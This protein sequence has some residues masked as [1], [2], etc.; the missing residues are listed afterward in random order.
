M[1]TIVIDKS[2]ERKK[3][4]RA[5]GI[6]LLSCSII[7]ILF[8]IIKWNKPVI[9]KPLVEEGIEVNL[10]DGNTGTGDIEPQVPGEPTSPTDNASIPSTQ[11]ET[12]S[13]QAD[14]NGDVPTAIPKTNTPVIKPDV[15][16]IIPKAVVQPKP[17]QPKAQMTKPKNQSGTRSD[18]Y[19][20]GSQGINGGHGNQGSPDGNPNASNY[21]DRSGTGSGISIKNGLNG[22]RITY[23]KM[24]GNFNENAKVAIDV[25]V[26]AA[27]KL[28]S[29]AIS[30]K[31]TTTSNPQTRQSAIDQLKKIK[32]SA[33]TE[34]QSGT[35]L[36]DLKL[37]LT[38]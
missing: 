26:D 10:G 34:E 22:R 20:P 12:P 4:L 6:T 31:G 29:Y 7:F 5:L 3:N 2:F 13:Q 21:G 28:I 38:N 11:P 25:V 17:P 19:K 36:F 18:D 37:R 9:E 15:K 24:E 23:P 32:F 35:I 27:G 1:N 16:P 8:Y 30:T 14:P 33:G